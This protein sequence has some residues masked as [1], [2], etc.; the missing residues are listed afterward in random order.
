HMGCCN[1][2]SDCV[3]SEFGAYCVPSF[4]M[5]DE[6]YTGMCQPCLQDQQNTGCR[7]GQ[8]CRWGAE[9]LIDISQEVE[10]HGSVR[11]APMRSVYWCE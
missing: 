8:S 2:D 5:D 9:T 11:G 3:G 6:P 1:E 7:R 10:E 4:Q